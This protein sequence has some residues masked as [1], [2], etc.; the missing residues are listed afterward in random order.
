[1]KNIHDVFGDFYSPEHLLSYNRPWMISLGTRSIGKSSGWLIEAIFSYLRYGDRFIYM[2]RTED[3]TQI[4]AKKCCLSPEIIL[5]A[6]GYPIHNIVA[7]RGGFAL[8]RTPDSDY[9][10]IGKYIPLSLAHK[11]KS[12]NYGSENYNWIIYDE[13]I[14]ID[15]NVY[16]GKKTNP[17]FEY[18][19]L[20]EFYQTV[21]RGVGQ[22]FRNKCKVVLI[23]N[24]ASYYNPIFLALGVDKYLRTDT[25]TL[26]PKGAKWVLEQTKGVKA[27]EDY[28][29]SNVYQLSNARNQEYAY[30]GIAFDESPNFVHRINR[31]MKALYNIKYSNQVYGVWYDEKD[32]VIYISNKR[33]PLPA[34]ALTVGDQDMVDYT[35]AIRPYDDQRINQLKQLYKLGRVICETRKIKYVVSNYFMLTP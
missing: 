31:P 12:T 28:K 7:K 29:N 30:E 19:R 10:E 6:S 18:D 25:K 5:K 2:R 20:I 32:G 1:M 21:D 3:E 8:Q 11:N 15:S 4:A 14:N 17:T 35:L 16:L 27:T 26:A 23:A 13:F 33:S 22:A 24:L 34:I 9:E